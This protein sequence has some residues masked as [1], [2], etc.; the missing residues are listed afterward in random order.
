[1]AEALNQLCQYSWALLQLE[2]SGSIIVTRKNVIMHSGGILMQ[3]SRKTAIWNHAL[4]RYTP[5]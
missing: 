2:W 1:M 4:W 5:M 3:S